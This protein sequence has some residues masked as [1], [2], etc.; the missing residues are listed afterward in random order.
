MLHDDLADAPVEQHR[1]GRCELSQQLR[2]PGE[3]KPFA[4]FGKSI[5]RQVGKA[6]IPLPE[7]RF[8]FAREGRGNGSPLHTL[9]SHTYR[10]CDERSEEHTSELQS[11]MRISYAVFCLKKKKQTVINTTTLCKLTQR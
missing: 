2:E 4:C 5:V 11:L 6:A 7:Q 3:L 10:R 1:T 8:C 9:L